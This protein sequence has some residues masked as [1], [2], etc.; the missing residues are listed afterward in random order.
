MG[1]PK[2]NMFM[3]PPKELGLGHMTTQQTKCVYGT[4][5]AGMIWEE[6]YRQ[7]LEDL[8]FISGR[9]NPCGFHHPE[10]KLSLLV[11]GDGFTA[12]GVDASIDKLEAGL[13][14]SFEIKVRG[15]IG[16]HSPLK[17]MRIL[18]SIVTLTNKGILYE[19]DP[20]HAKLLV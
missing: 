18:N 7:R 14:A 16:K 8:G 20:R 6:T 19:A 5:D 15:H 12:L 13:K 9:A 3:A 4:R 2:R 1:K 10:W 11:H 17:K